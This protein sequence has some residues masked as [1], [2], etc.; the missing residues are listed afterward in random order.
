MVK[1]LEIV[2]V[3]TCGLAY[4]NWSF[5]KKTCAIK[6]EREKERKREWE[7]KSERE[8]MIEINTHEV[9]RKIEKNLLPL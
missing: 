4:S 6:R 3:Y 1:V 9:D 2:D 7:R 8:R 5:G